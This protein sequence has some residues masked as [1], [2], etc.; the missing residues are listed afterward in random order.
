MNGI[1]I[2]ELLINRGL[3][4]LEPSHYAGSILNK[5]N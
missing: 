2:Q 1:T 3:L 4:K 5:K